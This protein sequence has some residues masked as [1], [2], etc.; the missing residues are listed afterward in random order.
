M[1]SRRSQIICAVE[2]GTSHTTAI[3]GEVTQEKRSLNIIGYGRCP[4]TGVVKGVITDLKAAG[5]SIHEAVLRAE[6]AAGGIKSDAV[7]LATTGAHV[8]G[9]ENDVTH[10]V[11][12]SSGV[13]SRADVQTVTALARSKC[14]PP[15]MTVIHFVRGQFRVDNK[16][17]ANPELMRGRVL[18]VRYWIAHGRTST[19]SDAIRIING[20][21]LGV[22]DIILSSL[23]SAVMVTEPEERR[24][25]VLVIDIGAGTTDYVLYRNGYVQQT[26]VVAV[27]GNHINGDLTCAFHHIS[28]P[29]A[30]ILKLRHGRSECECKD[31]SQKVFVRG[32]RSPGDREVSLQSVEKVI[33]VR[34]EELFEVIRKRLG[35]DLAAD[36]VNSGVVLTG[37]TSRLPRIADT[38]S[39]V[40]GLPVR[41]GEN[42]DWVASDL[43]GPE[44]S[45]ALGVLHYGLLYPGERIGPRNGG[46]LDRIQSRNGGLLDRILK[47][48]KLA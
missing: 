47:A 13:I 11:T 41:L 30:E 20:L 39:R 12:S 8:G 9:F 29:E 14:P 22:Q 18:G 44:F 6:K 7:F 2:I 46:L 37:G 10:N 19:L 15:D 40:L 24:H 4:S 23:A 5:Q 36:A 17:V 27:G 21:T 33:A 26:G 35:D 45:T 16:P 25:G 32:D 34:V 1:I 28:Q 42:P 31:R 43:R 48:F 3:M 38:A